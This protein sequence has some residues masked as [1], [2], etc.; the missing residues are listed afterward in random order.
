MN[1]TRRRQLHIY[2]I[3]KNQGTGVINISNEKLA[4]LADVSISSI[5]RDLDEM[6]NREIIIRETNLIT[7]DG[8]TRKQRDIILREEKPRRFTL[9]QH[10]QLSDLSNHRVLTDKYGDVIWERRYDGEWERSMPEKDF[11]DEKQAYS[12]VYSAVGQHHKKY[13][14]GDRYVSRAE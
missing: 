1:K 3:L 13:T 11:R 6:D 7:A 8:K 5:K 2:S 9:N 14:T 4:A 12:W 10:K